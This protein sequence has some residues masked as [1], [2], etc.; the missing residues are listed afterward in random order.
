[1]DCCMESIR[2]R[3]VSEKFYKIQVLKSEEKA[4]DDSVSFFEW[5][6]YIALTKSRELFRI[7]FL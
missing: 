3:A 1:M 2:N 6:R 5:S 4:C 7:T